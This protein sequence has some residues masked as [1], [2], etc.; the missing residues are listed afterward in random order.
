MRWFQQQ[1]RINRKMMSINFSRK[2][3]SRAFSSII[4]AM[5]KTKTHLL[6]LK[7]FSCKD[8][9]EIFRVIY[10][11]EQLQNVEKGR[12]LILSLIWIIHKFRGELW[13][14]FT[15]LRRMIILWPNH[16]TPP[17]S[18]FS[19]FNHFIL[20]SN[21]ITFALLDFCDNRMREHKTFEQSRAFLPSCRHEVVRFHWRTKTF[22]DENNNKWLY[23]SNTSFAF[24]F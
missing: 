5:A 15:L 10:C 12:P 18:C 24:Y 8:E 23:S 9:N 4:C 3:L 19:T 1:T 16:S 17:L 22:S 14:K 6:T 2:T 21:A 13:A 20:K 7:N 11:K